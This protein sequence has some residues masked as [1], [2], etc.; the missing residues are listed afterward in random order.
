M[1][2]RRIRLQSMQRNRRHSTWLV[3]LPSLLLLVTPACVS[4][5]ERARLIKDNEQ[6]RRET[7]GLERMVAQ[8]DGTIAQLHRQIRDLQGF[9]PDR[10]VDLF[11]PV[12]IEVASRSGGADYDGKPGDDGVTVYLRLRDA[13][14]DI[15]KAPGWITV[16][17]LD[18][19][20]L[21]SPRLIGVYRFDDVG[22]LR[23]AWYGKFGTQHYS[24]KCPFPPQVA[25][26][27]T[28]DVKIEFVDWLTGRTLTANQE[29]A[30]SFRDRDW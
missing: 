19:R 26:P 29:V 18:N 10:P 16:Q 4:P 11:A 23:K 9:G 21:G 1:N 2:S 7:E 20:N 6:L 13:D 17:L 30:V 8:R 24:L 3:G 12:T 14:G 27:R 22:Q 28:V 5:G 15:V 25:P